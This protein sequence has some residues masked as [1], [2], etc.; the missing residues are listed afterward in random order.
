MSTKQLKH[1]VRNIASHFNVPKTFIQAEP[2]GKGHINDTY[3]ATYDNNGKPAKYIHQRINNIVFKN[4]IAL[5]ENVRRVTEHQK[6]QLK[7]A[8]VPDAQRRALTLIPAVDGMIYYKDPEGSIWRT[9]IFIDD[10]VTFDVIDQPSLAFEAARAF[11]LF[12]KQLSTLAGERL[13]DTIPDFHNTPKRFQALEKAIEADTAN[14]AKDAKQEIEFAM[15]HKHIIDALIKKHQ[16]GLMPERVTHNDTKINNVMIDNA[17]SEGICV[18]D[19]DTVM[20]GLLLYDFGDMVRSGTISSAE[21]EQDLSKVHIRLPLFEA[22][23]KGFTETAGDIMTKAEKECIA[24]SG[25][26]ITLEIG[27]RFLTDY[28]MNDV[29]FKIHR[30]KHNLDRCRVQFKMVD[31]I[32]ENEEQMN[33]MVASLI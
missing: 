18:I 8:G 12:Q 22:L 14:R 10:A 20:N 32:N 4:P 17:T 30:E 26:I 27:I 21:D 16:Q 28:L 1:D 19:L 33:K 25:K 6:S 23:V 13:H 5:M 11:G 24:L 15:K 29:Y 31:S 9:Y 2:C 3:V 7:K